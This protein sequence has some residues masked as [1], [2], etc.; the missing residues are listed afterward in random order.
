MKAAIVKTKFEFVTLKYNSKKKSKKNSLIFLSIFLFAFFPNIVN[1]YMHVRKETP[2]ILKEK[3][4]CKR[5]WY[6][7]SKICF[8]LTR[9]VPAVLLIYVVAG[10]FLNMALSCHTL[11]GVKDIPCK[12]SFVHQCIQKSVLMPEFCL[13]NLHLWRSIYMIRIRKSYA[14]INRTQ[15]NIIKCMKSLFTV[16]L[17]LQ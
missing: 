12:C 9:R 11:P 14:R 3:P 1:L 10:S 15:F 16:N 17:S 6:I 8:S 13:W 2:K 5:L 7:M 4:E